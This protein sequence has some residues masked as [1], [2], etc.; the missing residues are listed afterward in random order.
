[1][2]WSGQK[3][4]PESTHPI[5]PA[6]AVSPQ[7]APNP[8]PGERGEKMEVPKVA[9]I[10]K[11]LHFRGDLS[12]NE[13]LAIEGAVEGKI[14]LNGYKVTIGE[15]GRVAAEIHAKSVVV[16]GLVKGNISAD[17]RVEVAATGTVL[18]DV[19]APRVVLVDGARFN[20]SI[21]MDTKSW[22]GSLVAA[23]TPGRSTGNPSISHDEPP[24][25]ASATKS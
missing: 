7:V 21:D 18:G 4:D 25:Y 20:G 5:P 6:T 3:S 15:T 22:P 23:P 1:M 11:S 17:E 24:A 16:G 19:R 13:D 8:S 10:G 14:A 12:G 2:T 9:S